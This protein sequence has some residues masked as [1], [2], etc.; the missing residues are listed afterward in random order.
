VATSGTYV[1]PQGGRRV[2]AAR[3]RLHT[4]IGDAKCD[5]LTARGIFGAQEF[6][7]TLNTQYISGLSTVDER[8]LILTDIIQNMMTSANMALVGEAT[9]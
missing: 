5:Q 7:I 3:R 4:Y 2:V 8:M 1:F 9:H 6:A